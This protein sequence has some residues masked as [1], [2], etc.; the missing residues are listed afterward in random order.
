ME[1]SPAYLELMSQIHHLTASPPKPDKEYNKLIIDLFSEAENDD[2]D[3]VFTDNQMIVIENLNVTIN[4]YCDSQKST[5]KH[6]VFTK[7]AFL[8]FFQIICTLIQTITPYLPNPGQQQ[9]TALL[10][11]EID[12]MHNTNETLI[13]IKEML[14]NATFDEAE[15]TDD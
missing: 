6:K 1:H 12:E 8:T 7:K 4:L 15:K 3:F 13:E 5:A 10:E 9:K 2:I 11:H 14:E